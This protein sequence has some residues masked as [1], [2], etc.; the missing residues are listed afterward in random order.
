M[1]LA[2]AVLAIVSGL[3]KKFRR[4]CLGLSIAM[5]I[6]DGVRR[7]ALCRMSDVQTS[8]SDAKEIAQKQVEVEQLKT[9]NSD[10]KENAEAKQ[11]VANGTESEQ[12]Q[13]STSDVEVNV[14]KSAQAEPL[15][16][17]PS[18]AINTAQKYMDAR[19][20]D[21]LAGIKALLAD[22]AV[23]TIPKLR[24]S[25]SYRGW[26]EIER[27]LKGTPFP[28]EE[29][30]RGTDN[31][32]VDSCSGGI[33]TLHTDFEVFKYLLWIKLRATVKISAD[34]KILDLTTTRL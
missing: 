31:F 4:L 7:R 1:L 17:L 28:G 12:L 32:V 27:F 6:F 33:A 20:K 29:N 8:T 14:Q 13:T 19:K 5:C 22:D 15:Q 10:A 3:R 18:D 26:A 11:R 24:G 9:S 16:T 23:L 2:L 25:N 30:Q 21:D 34:N